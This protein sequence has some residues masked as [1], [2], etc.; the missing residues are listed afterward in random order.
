MEQL[1]NNGAYALKMNGAGFAAERF[2]KGADIHIC[3][4]I[5]IH[6]FRF[7]MKNQICAETLTESAV[8]LKIPGIGFQ[9]LIGPELSGVHKN[10]DHHDVIFF[11]AF[12]DQTGVAFMK[13]AHGGHEADAFPFFFPAFD[14]FPR[15]I[16][17]FR[18]LHFV[19]LPSF[20]FDTSFLHKRRIIIKNVT[21]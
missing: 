16:D 3:A 15:L 7:R 4:G 14:K 10:G 1:G 9:I 8:S 12:L 13:K 2:R 5:L 17:G 20:I 19:F 21:Y 11:T 6:F 18:Y